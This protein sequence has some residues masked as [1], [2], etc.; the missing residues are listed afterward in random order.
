MKPGAAAVTGGV[1]F[2]ILSGPR[3][4]KQVVMK[5]L[6]ELGL[7]W[8]PQLSF[9]TFTTVSSSGREPSDP[10]GQAPLPPEGVPWGAPGLT[11]LESGAS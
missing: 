11:R 9:P 5:P 2:L 8:G 3:Q 6:A 1:D 10:A 7:G 4:G